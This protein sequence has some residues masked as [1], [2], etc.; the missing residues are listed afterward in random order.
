MNKKIAIV[1]G[2]TSGIGKAT[3]LAL[4]GAGYTVY[5]FSR[6]EAGVEGLHH[7]RADITDETQVRAAVQQV[8]DAEGQIDVVVN[9]AGF[10][11]SG[12]VE[13]TDT[14]DAQRLFNADF[15]GMVR[16]NRAVI[17]HMRAAG[18]GRIV[19]LSSVAGPLPI[20]FQTYYSA[21][22]AAVNAYTMA[23]ANEL[24]PFGITVCAVQPGDIHT[25]F[26]AA[27]EKT[28]TGDEVYGGRISR[29]VS[30]MEH[31]EQTGMP[32]EKAAAF[33]CC[34]ALRRRTKPL[35][36]IGP[37]YSAAVLLGRLLPCRLVS[38]IVSKLYAA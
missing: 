24:R 6:R 38:W 25:G 36:A 22:K 21:A 18:R 19:N 35:Y 34:V 7:I 10:G 31:D 17:A 11:I 1:T 14:A 16:V 5:E 13:F 33:L 12:A 20:P 4:R 26:T 32:P 15:F 37:Q 27:R 30:R 23:L 3:A 9:N 28:V 8:M 29:S 2:G